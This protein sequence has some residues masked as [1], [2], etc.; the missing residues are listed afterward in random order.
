MPET[1][2]VPL[3][4]RATPRSVADLRTA[5]GIYQRAYGACYLAGS[6]QGPCVVA[7]NPDAQ[8]HPLNLTGYTRTLQISG[9][10]VLD[11]GTA[12]VAAPGPPGTLGALSAVVAF[13]NL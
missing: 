6:P 8:A 4:P 7:V 12:R 5:S 1:Q 3:Q 10:G 9:G 13:R 11:G 2:L